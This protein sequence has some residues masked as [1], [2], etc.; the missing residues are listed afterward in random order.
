MVAR[1]AG[2]SASTVSRIINGTVNVSDPLRS[3]VEAAIAKFDFKP[4]AAARGLALGKTFTIGVVAGALDS[5]LYWEGYRGIEVCV[6]HHGY[7]P[8]FM[9]GNRH[10][11]DEDDDLRELIA[12]GVDGIIVFAGRVSDAK[13]QRYARQ[14]PIVVTGR[15]LRSR[16]VFSLQIDAG[17]G[18]M[19][20]VRHLFELGHRRIA[21]ITGSDH[22][23]EAAKRLAGYKR[24][25][26]IAGVRFDPQL[27]KMG[28]WREEGGVR[29]TLELLDANQD[30][31]ALLC[32]NDQTAY[33]ALL[34][35]FRKGLKVPRDVS[36][37][38]L[39]DLRPSAFQVP[40]L[41]SV[42]QSMR[43]L[44]EQSARAVF[45]LLA[46]RRPRRSSIPA[47]LIV[48]ESTARMSRIW[49]R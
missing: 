39:D 40:P 9:S 42:R 31:T 23:P 3:A 18:V 32:V 48:R 36:V 30:F 28:D 19:L 10:E 46:G 27:V 2:V 21:F 14:V 24:A 1:E 12:R 38:G 41:T 33:G 15:Q 25:L 35:L 43:T 8:L 29:A 16:G 44:G 4:N 26:E 7:V 11:D 5:P 34:G 37:V 6:R 47:Q 13:L 45:E 17:Q 22:R 20:A 49:M